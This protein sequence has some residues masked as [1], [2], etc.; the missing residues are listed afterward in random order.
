MKA[1]LKFNLPEE[2]EEFNTALKGIDYYCAL[3]DI[4]VWLK[5]KLKYEELNEEESKIYEKFQQA[6]NEVLEE[7]KVDLN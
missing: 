2:N 5:Q 7:N 6:F 4:S 1:I 3:V